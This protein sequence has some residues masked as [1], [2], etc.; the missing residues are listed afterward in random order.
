MDGSCEQDNGTSGSRRGGNLTKRAT[1]SFSKRML[2]YERIIAT[3]QATAAI[4]SGIVMC[5]TAWKLK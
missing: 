4:F 5:S 3:P 1:D 2:L